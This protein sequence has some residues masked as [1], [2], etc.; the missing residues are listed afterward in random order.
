MYKIRE[1]KTKAEQSE[2]MVHEICRDI[3]KLDFAKK[4]ITTTITVLYRLKMLASGN[5][6]KRQYKEAAAQLEAVNQC[7]H[8]EAY[9]DIPKMTELREK[10]KNIK[11]IPSRLIKIEVAPKNYLY[12]LILQ[13]NVRGIISSC[14]EPHLIVYVE[15]EEKTLMANLE[16]LIQTFMNERGF[17]CIKWVCPEVETRLLNSWDK[18]SLHATVLDEF[19][20]VITNALVTSVL[21][22]ETKF[23]AEMA[24]MTRVPWGS[25]EAV[26]D[27]SDLHHLLVHDSMPIV[28]I[29]DTSETETQQAASTA[30]DSNFVTP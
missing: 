15:L 30:S 10:F 11:Q 14:F 12:S 28:S 26:G 25:L 16:K 23:D 19:S 1:I 7:N 27:Q 13:C 18:M 17:N 6:F 22:L 8:F 9:R 3:K 29:A 24:A 2:T 4:R 21:G 20:A 5:G